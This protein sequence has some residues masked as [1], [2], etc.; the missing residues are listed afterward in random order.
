[1]ARRL[2][3]SNDLA[4]RILQLELNQW[5]SE[6]MIIRRF[7]IE[8]DWAKIGEVMASGNSLESGNY[9]AGT[10]GW[11]IDGDGNA[12]FNDVTVRGTIYASAGEIGALQVTSS[13][14]IGT[15]GT[16]ASAGG[17]GYRFVLSPK[18]GDIINEGAI[19]WYNNSNADTG[20]IY[21]AT[22]GTG[23]QYLLIGAE[24]TIRLQT[25]GANKVYI[26]DTGLNVIPSGTQAAPSLCWNAN[27]DVGFYYTADQLVCTINGAWKFLGHTN[28][29][30]IGPGGTSADPSISWNTDPDTG[31][32]LGGTNEIDFSAGGN[33]KLE[34]NATYNQSWQQ[35]R[36]VGGTASV[37]GIAWSSDSDTG[38]YFPT[39][40]QLAITLAGTQ[41]ALF[42]GTGTF[43]Q[44]IATRTTTNS[45]NVWVDTGSTPVGDL[46]RS[47][48]SLR[49][50]RE[51][52]DWNG[53]FSVLDLTPITFIG[54]TQE[55][56]QP[57]AK[58]KYKLVSSGQR[59]LGIAAEEVAELFPWAVVLDEDGLPDAINWNALIAGL[60]YETKVL[61]EELRAIKEA[62]A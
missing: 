12:E 24:D 9:V 32:F 3:A 21:G 56:T 42:G 19:V 47:T 6:P 59:Y 49:Y 13:L 40:G 4:A 34:L 36:F 50:K 60:I 29:L 1:M 51:V 33:I 25:S 15:F 30:R 48:S 11:M 62:A 55:R 22:A 28:G 57:G 61:K 5:E 26:Q 20:Y 10:S 31:I 37:P 46:R 14:Y 44:N 52:V 35:H 41:E 2:V 38:I 7:G 45:A 18:S 27:T 54:M 58:N 17:T 16:L 43:I 53:D 8:V 39:T 23:D